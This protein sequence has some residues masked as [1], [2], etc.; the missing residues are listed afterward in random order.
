MYFTYFHSPQLVSAAWVTSRCIASVHIPF[1]FI[2][3]KR[4]NLVIILAFGFLEVHVYGL[5]YP[6]HLDDLREPSCKC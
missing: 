1:P 6:L 4:H 5:G 2:N 3:E